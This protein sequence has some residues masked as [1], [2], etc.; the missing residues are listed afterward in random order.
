MVAA[1]AF[2]RLGGLQDAVH[3]YDHHGAARHDPALTIR[4]GSA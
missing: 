1:S 4:S 3:R 2:S